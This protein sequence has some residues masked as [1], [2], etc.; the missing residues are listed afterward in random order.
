MPSDLVNN[1][2]KMVQID[3][4]IFWKIF[5]KYL[6]NQGQINLE[7]FFGK[8]LENQFWKIGKS[9]TG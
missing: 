6:E 8:F 3:C 5:G 7:N 2:R 9:S 4:T 1:V